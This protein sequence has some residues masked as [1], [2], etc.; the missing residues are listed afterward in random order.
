MSIILICALETNSI[1][2]CRDLDKMICCSAGGRFGFG[3][4]RNVE[5]RL[6]YYIRAEGVFA[7]FAILSRDRPVARLRKRDSIRT[8]LGG[9]DLRTRIVRVVFAISAL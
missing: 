9:Q 1:A 3:V 4:N 5:I 7:L 8:A 2:G 6:N